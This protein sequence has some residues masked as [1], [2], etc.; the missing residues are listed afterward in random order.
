ML[1][2]RNNPAASVKDNRKKS[3][4]SFEFTVETVQNFANKEQLECL[5]TGIL[6]ST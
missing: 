2:E 5:H 6:K 3:F 4:L 1:C